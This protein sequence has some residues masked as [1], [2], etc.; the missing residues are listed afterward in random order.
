LI[1]LNDVSFNYKGA[2]ALDRISLDIGRGEYVAIAGPNASGK[3]TLAR[4]MNALLLPQKGDCI[5][6]G[7]NTKDDP[8]HARK[9]VGMVFQDPEIQVVARHV[10]E[11]VAFGP[12]N[13]GL[14]K[15]EVE[16]RVIEALRAVGLKDLA[17]REV[18]GLSGGQ[19]QLLAIAGVL[20]MRPSFVILDEPASF[21]DHNGSRLVREAITRL[22]DGGFGVIVIT[23]DMGE[24]SRAKRIIALHEGRVIADGPPEGFF[25]DSATMA[26]L[27]VEPPYSYRLIQAS[28][29]GRL[30][31][32]VI[33]GCR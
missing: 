5:V 24:A 4:I 15:S 32:E 25:S 11:D 18:S 28:G 6:D 21:L 23:H 2:P 26:I 13:L 9:I 30:A 14:P 33:R 22:V 31:K 12:R 19:K 27:G 29:P 3:S 10:G 1:S 8:M 20:A 16:A 7:V 17:G